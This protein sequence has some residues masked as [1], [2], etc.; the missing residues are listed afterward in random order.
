MQ[1]EFKDKRVLI[2][3]GNGFLGSHLADRVLQEGGGAAIFCRGTSLE[4]VEHLKGN[5]QVEIILGDIGDPVALKKA[6]RQIDVVFHLSAQTNVKKSVEVPVEDFRVTVVGTVELLQ[7]M[8]DTGV[9]RLLYVSAGRVYGEPQYTP[10]DE[11][12]PTQPIDPYGLG[13]YVGEQYCRFYQEHHGIKSIILRLFSTYGER[14]LPK[15]NSI[16]GV[17]GIFSEKLLENQDISILGDGNL[18][19]DFLYISDFVNIVVN[20]AKKDLWGET[21]NVASGSQVSMADLASILF[22]IIKPKDAKVV[23]KDP[24]PGDINLHPDVS[25]LKE[26]LNIQTFTPLEEGLN[27]YIHWLKAYKKKKVSSEA[28]AVQSL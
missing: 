18:K 10:V 22:D 12:H 4:N 25:H 1:L 11:G 15:P 23:Y 13:K 27:N 21:F 20:V 14:L 6:L 17:V 9:N 28:K 8:K 2:T 16:T 19:R 26:R 7:A 24:A 3:G 5:P